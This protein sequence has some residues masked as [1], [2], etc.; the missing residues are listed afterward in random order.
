MILLK[1]IQEILRKVERKYGEKLEIYDV[2]EAPKGHGDLSLPC[3]KLSRSLR[4][5]P[6]EISKDLSQEDWSEIFEEVK[7]EGPYLNFFLNYSKALE[8]VYEEGILRFPHRKKR[9]LVEHTSANPTGP[10]HVG[11]GRNPII[12]DSIARILKEYGYEVIREYYVDDMGYQVALLVWGCLKFGFPP[13][14]DLKEYAEIYKKAHEKEDKEEVMRLLREYERGKHR[15]LFSKVVDEVMRGILEELKDLGIEFDR[16]TKESEFVFSGEVEKVLEK[17]QEKGL[18]HVDESGA[19]YVDVREISPE[20]AKNME[21]PKV[22]LTRSDGTSL[23]FLR[24][25]AYHLDKSKRAEILVNVLGED[26]KLEGSLIREIMKILGGKVP[27]IL[28]YSFVSLPEGR[29]STRKGRV[30]YLRDLMEEGISRALKE[31]MERRPDLN[32]KEAKEI[33][34]K[35][36]IG[37]V[38]FNIVKTQ[39][40]KP[41]KFRWEEAL[42]L[43][44]DSAPFVMYSYVRCL[45][46]LKK[47]SENPTP[48]FKVGGEEERDLAYKLLKFPVVVQ[49]A[50]EGKKPHLIAK[51]CLDVA[52]SFNKFY[53]R[54]PVLKEPDPEARSTRLFLVRLTK[55]VL[56]RGMSLLGI[57][58]PEKMRSLNWRQEPRNPPF[59]LRLCQQGYATVRPLIL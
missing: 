44:K 18:L 19:K 21:D 37:A 53:D 15:E 47:S 12:G 16:L 6:Q 33:A 51:Y 9:A 23:Y 35:V 20:I 50:A 31:V 54:W 40:E 4:I 45:G 59:L 27:E 7:A 8:E 17:L 29:M 43:E 5:P 1:A 55:E 58:M 42:S 11:R 41:I 57:E 56:E 30:V 49:E 22:Y 34:R 2:V 38:K 10:L 25:I 14:G 46:I 24:D 28:F 36:G 13:S 3:F 32:E 48:P 52:G 26:H 39:A